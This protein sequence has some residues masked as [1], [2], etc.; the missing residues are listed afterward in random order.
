MMK[1]SVY[2]ATSL[3]GFIARP[4]G[5]LDW[6]GQPL[7]DGED[8]GYKD[9]METVDF[10]VMGRNTYDVVAS[11]GEWP[12]SKPVVVL[13]TRPL[14]IPDELSDHVETISGSPAEIITQLSERGAKHLYIDGGKTIQKFIEDHLIQRLII[15][16]IPVLL[17]DGIR[18][19][20]PLQQ[21]VRLRLVETQTF[22]NGNVQAEYELV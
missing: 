16:T 6:L 1:A 20:G 7:E 4:N 3:D 2:I 14:S 21:D 13:T 19:F 5:E 18:L 11:F 10:L 15:T 22:A 12:Y 9:F 8:Y 17:G